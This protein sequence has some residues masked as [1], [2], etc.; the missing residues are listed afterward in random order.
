ML[1]TWYVTTT[2]F[3]DV[4]QSSKWRGLFVVSLVCDD[5]CDD[6]ATSGVSSVS[7]TT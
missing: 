7:S 2:S 4:T 3:C 5:G 6:I 1:L